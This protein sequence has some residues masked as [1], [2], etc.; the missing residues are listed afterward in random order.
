MDADPCAGACA[1]A[2]R[3]STPASAKPINWMFMT[4]EP[5]LSTNTKKARG[6]AARNPRPVRRP[7][8]FFFCATGVGAGVAFFDLPKL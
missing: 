5:E 7:Q 8:G 4:P 1:L 2:V 6:G 3:A